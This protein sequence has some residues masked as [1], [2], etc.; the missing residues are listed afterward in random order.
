MIIFATAPAPNVYNVNHGGTKPRAPA[1][2]IG[3]VTKRMTIR[4]VVSVSLT[5]FPCSVG[6]LKLLSTTFQFLTNRPIHETVPFRH[7]TAY[8]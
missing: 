8:M 2:S 6:S 1:Y 7:V 3:S 4:F 5:Y